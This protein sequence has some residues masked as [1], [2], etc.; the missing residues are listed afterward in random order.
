MG[1]LIPGK[2]FLYQTDG[3]ITGG[4]GGAYER[5]LS[6]FLMTLKARAETL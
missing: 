3:L 2:D 6:V 5:D 4:G 1:G